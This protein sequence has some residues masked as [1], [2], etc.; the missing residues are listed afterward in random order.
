MTVRAAVACPVLILF[1]LH[2]PIAGS[3]PAA[4]AGPTGDPARVTSAAGVL[5][6]VRVHGNYATPDDTVLQLAGLTLGQPVSSTTAVEAD[7]RLRKSGRF[8]DVEVRTRSR[9]L[10]GTDIAIVIVVSEHDGANASDTDFTTPPSIGRR[11]MSKLM[12]LPVLD[13]ADGYG[14]TYGARFT[15]AGVA[16]RS[17][18]LSVPLT[19]GGTKR[20]AAEFEWPIG[21]RHGAASDAALRVTLGGGWS[22]RENPHYNTDEERLEIGAGLSRDLGRFVRASAR[23]GL[24]DLRFA[25]EDDRLFTYGADLTLDTRTDPAFP[26]NAVVAVVSWDGTEAREAGR[27]N[28]YRLEAHGYAGLVGK[29]VLALGTR[30]DRADRALPAYAQP[31]LGGADTLRGFRPG[32]FASDNRFIASAELRIPFSSPLSAGTTGVALFA[33]AGASYPDGVSLKH[34]DFERGV[35]AGFFVILPIGSARVDVAHGIDSGTRAHV[36]FGVRF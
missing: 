7:A 6:E 36:S 18:R 34:A 29:S 11:L 8:A 19:W 3:Q 30:Y 2:A 31:L 1:L 15:F 12:F 26:R 22:S 35:G 13:Y 5:S 27:S 33:D 23:A 24:T 4:Q 32:T 20:A 14:F 9:S 28:R 25:S 21:A 10:S 17:G 16:G